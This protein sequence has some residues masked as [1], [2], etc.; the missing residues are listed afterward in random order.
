MAIDD[1]TQQP[2]VPPHLESLATTGARPFP[3]TD[4]SLKDF[5]PLTDTPT[6]NYTQSELDRRA[7]QSEDAERVTEG[8]TLSPVQASLRRLG[9]DRRAMVCL[10]LILTVVL[11]SYVFPIFYLHIGPT[12]TGGPTGSTLIGPEVYH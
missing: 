6:Q 5:G 1:G 4:E 10:G 3:P 12:I 2:G 8:Q 7:A 9:R 11:L